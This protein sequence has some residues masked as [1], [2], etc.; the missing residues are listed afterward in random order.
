MPS[1]ADVPSPAPHASHPP[2]TPAA[3]HR[4]STSSRRVEINPGRHA[5]VDRRDPV[6]PE[7]QRAGVRY[8]AVDAWMD[9]DLDELDAVWDEVLDLIGSDCDGYSYVSSTAGPPDRSPGQR[10]TR[11]RSRRVRSDARPMTSWRRSGSLPTAR[12]RQPGK[13]RTRRLRPRRRPPAPARPDARSPPARQRTA[14]AGP[15]QLGPQ[16]A[17]VVALAAPVLLVVTAVQSRGFAA[18]S[19]MPSQPATEPCS[20]VEA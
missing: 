6:E 5:G 20:R 13:R 12:R 17:H 11:Y 14:P 4:P 8:R 2:R 19:A 10:P 7:C 9:D 3:S 1:G 16:R 15:L 18:P